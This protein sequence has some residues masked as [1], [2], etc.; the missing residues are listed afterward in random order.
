MDLSLVL[1]SRTVSIKNEI[2]VNLKEFRVA[3]QTQIMLVKITLI[4]SIDRANLDTEFQP[5][6][7]AYNSRPGKENLPFP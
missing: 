7:W 4:N 5:L 6:I 3:A 1:D 2:Y